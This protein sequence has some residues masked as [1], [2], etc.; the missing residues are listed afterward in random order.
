[1]QKELAFKISYAPCDLNQILCVTLQNK[2]IKFD[3]KSGHCIAT[4][5]KIH[6][7]SIDSLSVTNDGRYLITSGDN[8][9]KIWDYEMRLEKNFQAFIGHSSSVDCILFTPDHNTLITVGD[10][11]IYWDFLAYLSCEDK[12]LNRKIMPNGRAIEDMRVSIIDEPKKNISQK[13][14]KS[15]IPNKNSKIEFK[16]QENKFEI[17]SNKK[18]TLTSRSLPSLKI[19]N[20]SSGEA[21]KNTSSNSAIHWTPNVV[22]TKNPTILEQI[23]CVSSSAFNDTSILYDISTPLATFDCYGNKIS[24]FPKIGID[25]QKGSIVS[26][27]NF[28]QK[29]FCDSSF[30]IIITKDDQ[31]VT[32]KP[33]LNFILILR[34]NLNLLCFSSFQALYCI[35]SASK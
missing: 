34:V 12:E 23:N 17:L 16:K 15:I 19:E 5:P 10:S 1:M 21:F 4:V 3:L 22:D 18:T 30:K 27:E 6:K 11:I 26:F 14:D 20:K 31:T 25:S 35:Q 13:L 32:S 33:F 7:N 24:Y 9:V 2:L 29:N 8:L 28:K